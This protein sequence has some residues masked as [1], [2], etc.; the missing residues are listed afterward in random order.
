MDSDETY[1]I[2]K[3]CQLIER[4]LAVFNYLYTIYNNHDAYIFNCVK[5]SSKDFLMGDYASHEVLSGLYLFCY[6]LH[7]RL[8]NTSPQEL[9][10]NFSQLC[11][12][13]EYYMASPT[14]KKMKMVRAKEFSE[15][16]YPKLSGD[17][18][19]FEPPVLLKSKSC[20]VYQAFEDHIVSM[21][22]DPSSVVAALFEILITYYKIF[23][24]LDYTQF[25]EFV[26]YV[27][28]IDSQVFR[29]VKGLSSNI[30]QIAQIK[31]KQY[32]EVFNPFVTQS[33]AVD[34]FFP[35]KQ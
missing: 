6:S 32:F 24:S 33:D 15:V 25:P 27:E 3:I 12:E 13:Y 23:S 30:T 8:E 20:I 34:C 7:S 4:R 18:C 16:N 10:K 2:K 35:Q 1:E 11:L 21:N 17:F 19:I 31:L 22:L 9:L 5:L 29:L 14:L 28:F 26:K